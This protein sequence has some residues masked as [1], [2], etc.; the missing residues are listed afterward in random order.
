MRIKSRFLVEVLCSFCLVAGIIGCK[1]NT[2]GNS[3]EKWDS[4]KEIW[5]IDEKADT[6]TKDKQN[7]SSSTVT[8]YNTSDIVKV[9][10]GIN[11]NMDEPGIDYYISNYTTSNMDPEPDKVDGINIFKVSSG[12]Y[13]EHPTDAGCTIEFHVLAI[14]KGE[15]KNKGAF[16]SYY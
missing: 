7:I 4:T 1:S 15:Y 13:F 14:K 12:E 9:K 11:G 3:E 2:E 16:I 5:A 10:F 6:P 8:I